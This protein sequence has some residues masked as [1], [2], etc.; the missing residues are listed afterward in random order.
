MNTIYTSPIA[1]IDI[2]NLGY[3]FQDILTPILDSL[4]GDFDQII[5]NQIVLWKV[6]RYAS[7]DSETLEKIN[8]INSKDTEIDV[9][10][11]KNIL[12]NLLNTKG[13]QLPMAST[14]LR[15]KNPNIYQIIDQ[16]VYRFI[17]GK[18]IKEPNAIIKK[19]DFY[20]NYLQELQFVCKEFKIDF[21]QSDRILYV[22]DKK[23]NSDK[24]LKNYGSMNS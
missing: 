10:F 2:K 4:D 12:H 18:K 11:T 20:I 3:N 23:F 15:F 7:F 6:N 22:M 5:L 24:N 8:R 19:I 16:R 17:F 13:V 14:I 9:D 1:E 21:N